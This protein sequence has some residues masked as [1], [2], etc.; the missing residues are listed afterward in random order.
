MDSSIVKF[1]FTAHLPT[2]IVLIY[3]QGQ[4]PFICVA[5]FECDVPFKGQ[6]L[7]YVPPVVTIRTASFN[8]Q[9]SAFLY[10]L[11]STAICSTL[12]VRSKNGDRNSSVGPYSCQCQVKLLQNS[13]NLLTTQ[14]VFKRGGGW[15]GEAAIVAEK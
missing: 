8:I 11:F 10:S 12:A 6:W 15:S 9:N 14:R 2:F 5:L 3:T 4:S 7:L 1:T 13:S